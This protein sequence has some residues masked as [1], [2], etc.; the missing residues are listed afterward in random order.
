MVELVHHL[1]FVKRKVRLGFAAK[2]VAVE[3]PSGALELLPRPEERRIARHV[4]KALL[5][6]HAPR[7]ALLSPTL[8]DE[9]RDVAVDLFRQICVTP[10]PEGRA[11][12]CV[13]V[14]ES[15]V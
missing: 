4:E 11:G 9:D 15:E 5:K 1:R 12:A 7:V 3:S 10:I 2:H 13:W 14:K 8:L 6:R